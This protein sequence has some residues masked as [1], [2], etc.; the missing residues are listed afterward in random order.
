MYG[1]SYITQWNY[2]PASRLK[3]VVATTVAGLTAT[4]HG[5]IE[6]S[7]WRHHSKAAIRVSSV[8]QECMHYPSYTCATIHRSTL[9]LYNLLYTALKFFSWVKKHVQNSAAQFHNSMFY[10]WP[11]HSNSSPGYKLGT[12]KHHEMRHTT[13]NPAMCHV[14]SINTQPKHV[15]C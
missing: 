11:F 8:R 15:E 9:Y 3:L 14:N 5:V 6:A 10:Q 12:N 13:F 1:Y 2:L 4:I 7:N